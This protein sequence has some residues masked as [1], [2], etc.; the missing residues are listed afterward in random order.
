ML[1]LEHGIIRGNGTTIEGLWG[2]GSWMPKFKPTDELFPLVVPENVFDG[3]INFFLNY[4]TVSSPRFHI[5]Y[6]D[7]WHEQLEEVATEY[8]RQTVVVDVAKNQ[9]VL[10][11]VLEWYGRDLG[12]D[13]TGRLRWILSKLIGDFSQLKLDTVN[14]KYDKY[15]WDFQYPPQI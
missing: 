1:K 5:L 4:G 14:V 11:K 15:D 9:I 12:L 13:E 3:R 10:P 7:R 2:L 6:A 8:L